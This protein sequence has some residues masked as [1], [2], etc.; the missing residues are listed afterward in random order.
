MG[1]M[2][3]TSKNKKFNK[4]SFGFALFLAFGFGC[5]CVQRLQQISTRDPGSF[6]KLESA[7]M[8]GFGRSLDE[9]QT[10]PEIYVKQK[11]IRVVPKDPGGD[12]GSLFQIDDERNYFFTDRGIRA[13]S[14]LNI[15]IVANTRQAPLPSTKALTAEAS[16]ADSAKNTPKTPK[17]TPKD[18]KNTKDSASSPAGKN[19]ALAAAG[20]VNGGEDDILKSLPQLDP[21]DRPA[22]ILNEFKVEVADVYD[23]G[24]ALVHFKRRSLR[25]DQAN[26]IRFSARIPYLR[27]ASGQGL[28][29]RDLAGVEWIESHEGQLTE[30]KSIGWEDEY[31]ARLS[32]F[33]EAKSKA[34]LALEEKRKQLK[35]ARDKLENRLHSFSEEREA[36]AKQREELMVKQKDDQTKIAE[37]TTTVEEQKQEIE[38]NKPEDKQG[39]KNDGKGGAK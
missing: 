12:S 7:P 30:R 11:S 3:G 31:S 19:A 36:F 25:D 16:L 23:N 35:D 17:D 28:T 22:G 4:L 27:L 14:T 5:G 6:D 8:D 20:A 33:E 34:A 24:D 21:G 38:K 39:D 37:L 9:V 1:V 32:G 2:T 18:P 10:S 13:G 26:E 29:T 15:A